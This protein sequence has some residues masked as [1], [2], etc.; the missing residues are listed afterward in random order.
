MLFPPKVDKPFMVAAAA[1]GI[2][3]QIRDALIKAAVS[4]TPRR[5]LAALHASGYINS[6]DSTVRRLREAALNQLGISF[7]P[8]PDE[9]SQIDVRDELADQGR[10][11][12][13]RNIQA[14][15]SK[16]RAALSPYP[17][18]VRYLH[19]ND[20]GRVIATADGCWYAIAS[21]PSE[22]AASV[23]ACCSAQQ[24]SPGPFLITGF[25]NPEVLKALVNAAR[26][27]EK[28][29]R[30][31]ID[32]IE[33]NASVAAIGFGC[34]DIRD[35]ISDSSIHWYIGSDAAEHRMRELEARIDDALPVVVM[36]SECIPTPTD[37]AMQERLQSLHARQREELI[38]LR[39]KI[40]A[41]YALRDA[42]WWK[43]R[44]GTAAQLRI[45]VISC[46]HTTFIRHAASDLAEAMRES[47]AAVRIV[48][49]SDEESKLTALHY[50]RAMVEHEPDIVI[51]MNFPRSTFRAAIPANVPYVC[52]IQDAMG[53][54]FDAEQG[55][56]LTEFDF[57]AGYLFPEL[58]EKFDYP[59][60][61]TLNCTVV[62]SDSKFHRN[63]IG[64]GSH[65]CEL[66]MVSH[67]GESPAKLHEKLRSRFE[68]IAGA[69][70]F[71]DELFPKVVIA[72]TQAASQHVNEALVDA[73]RSASCTTLGREL[74]D[75]SINRVMRQ[76][77]HP[78]ADRVFRH[79][80]IHWAADLADSR[81]W[82]LKLYGKGW[83]T[84]ERFASYA[85]GELE[86]GEQLRSAY[87]GAALH[88]HASITALAHQRVMECA[89]SGGLCLPRLH[90][91]MLRGTLREM[92]L[93]L[94]EHAPDEID[95]TCGAFIYHADS[96]PELSH[97]LAMWRTLGEE[98]EP[99]R[100]VIPQNAAAE[101]LRA[102]PW[103]RRVSDPNM[104]FGDLSANTYRDKKTFESIAIRAV[105]DPQW[106]KERADMIRERV[107]A[108]YT[109][110]VF[111]R[112]VIELVNRSFR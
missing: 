62:A 29:Y 27:D 106:R 80:L 43:H 107:S 104:I 47:G 44:F 3:S 21:V 60:A 48:E 52:W 95:P 13:E 4:T 14:L 82:R 89:L 57:N 2:P 33:P 110:R 100:L 5:F 86:H 93:E 77:A 72:A 111:A 35:L 71:L 42:A 87:Q 99:S 109:H 41:V 66:A 30:P 74:D 85:A 54:L 96:R 40:D 36:P 51:T 75:N 34:E 24:P 103:L 10:E 63:T 7:H 32:V 50:A 12:F 56:S 18:G 64:A 90:R 101:L 67:H 31:R 105:E 25:S 17:H 97:F 11:M 91:E 94:L 23:S 16:V 22:V 79:E 1:F 88:L 98:T 112:Q 19:A 26:S 102:R 39:A 69:Q 28:L 73:I 70:G 83:N 8:L 9:E 20:G 58:F 49:E 68:T 45:V 76:Y 15:H 59:F 61:R 92:Q 53:H 37:V 55:R 38:R 78:V 65:A 108:G 81:G 46:R 6:D 84:C